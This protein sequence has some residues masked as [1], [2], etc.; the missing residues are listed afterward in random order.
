MSGVQHL[1]GKII[2]Q[3]QQRDAIH[4]AVAPVIATEKLY[5]GQEVVWGDAHTNDGVRAGVVGEMPL[6]IVDPYLKGPVFPNQ[7]FWMFLMPGTVTVVRH[8]WVHPA[9]SAHVAG[10]VGSEKYVRDM[11]ER[12]D[13][14][15]GRL[16]EAAKDF[17]HEGRYLT[18]GSEMEGEFTPPEFWPHFEN[19]TGIKVDED[20]RE[21]FF[22]CSC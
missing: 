11:A 18:G 19:L 6:G 21:N 15:P 1:L 12:L 17:L 3:P 13:M 5:P 10:A 22:S 7:T 8:E 16:I 9:F 2:A 4:I 20:H 14:T